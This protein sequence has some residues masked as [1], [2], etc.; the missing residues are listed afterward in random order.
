MVGLKLK[1]PRHLCGALSMWMVVHSLSHG[2]YQTHSDL[3]SF[4]NF[5]FMETHKKKVLAISTALL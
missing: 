5:D 1:S 3:N 2:S 4:E